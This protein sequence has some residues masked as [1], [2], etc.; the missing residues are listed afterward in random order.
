M[1]R[2]G[3]SMTTT[4]FYEPPARDPREEGAAH[5]ERMRNELMTTRDA[6]RAT[7]ID[8]EAQA[9]RIDDLTRDLRQS[10]S[11]EAESMREAMSYR[12]SLE[13]VGRLVLAILKRGIADRRDGQPYAPPA[14]PTPQRGDPVSDDDVAKIETLLSR[15]RLVER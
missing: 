9:R 1:A 4:D 11:A 15:P 8:R 2:K 13:D 7:E 6:L 10:K 5:W 14:I 12:T 3:F